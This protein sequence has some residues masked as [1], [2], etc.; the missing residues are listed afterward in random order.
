MG[1]ICLIDLQRRQALKIFQKG[2][3]QRGVLSPVLGKQLLGPGLHRGDGDGD[4]RHADQQHDRCRNVDE[5]KHGKQRQRREHRIE[6]LRQVCT[7]IGFQL[8]HTFDGDLH[9]LGGLDLFVIR[10]AQA[11]E[12]LINRLTQGFFDRARGQKAH[13]RRPCGAGK[14]HCDGQCGK[15]RRARQLRAVCRAPKE[16]REQLRD[17]GHHADVGQQ[18]HPLQRDV[19]CD[20]LPALRH[21]VDQAFVHHHSFLHSSFG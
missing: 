7:E 8:I 3:A 6:E 4:Q 20:I 10:R 21:E 2:V 13:S 19:A 5:A 11:Q 9:D 17:R 15:N 14:A 12:L 1:R 16:R 18:A